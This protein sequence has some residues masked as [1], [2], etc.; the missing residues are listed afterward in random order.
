MKMPLQQTR[1]TGTMRVQKIETQVIREG[2]ERRTRR[3]SPGG[4]AQ[5]QFDALIDE[6]DETFREEPGLVRGIESKVRLRTYEPIYQR[7][8]AIPMVR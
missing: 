4:E 3:A 6:F 1:Q 5:G 2:E 8:Y 7:P